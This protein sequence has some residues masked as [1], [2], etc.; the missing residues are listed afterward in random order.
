MS[1]RRGGLLRVIMLGIWLAQLGAC[2]LD[3]APTGGATAPPASVAQQS[4][5]TQQT[6]QLQQLPV[7]P[8]VAPYRP[9]IDMTICP[10]DTT[11]VPRPIFLQAVRFMADLL[12]AAVVPNQGG[13]TAY[14]T[15]ITHQTYRP[16][17]TPLT[18]VIPPTPADPPP[19]T[20]LPPPSPTSDPF[21][22]AQARDR[23]RAANDATLRTYEALLVKQHAELDAVRRQV[24]VQTD[25][26]RRLAPPP[27]GVATSI[28]GCVAAG[29]ERVQ[30]DP[31]GACWL[32]LAGTDL[33]ENSWQD[34]TPGLRLPG[35]H[36]AVLF[37]Y[38]LYAPACRA[39]TDAWRAVFLAAGA[40]PDVRFVDP[41]QSRTLPLADFLAGGQRGGG[42]P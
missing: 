24:R 38:C 34:Y 42:R 28:W 37:Y 30:G 12:D 10:D 19:P 29:A 26:L 4:P 23:V 7:Q 1:T 32:V 13:V 41:A 35:C 6:Q 15:V 33:E 16:E 11:S 9:R 14:V 20:L 8:I 18:I 21:A 31:A 39:T 40:A 3:L 27:D 22:D 36:V 2:A 25:T 5:Q 17:S